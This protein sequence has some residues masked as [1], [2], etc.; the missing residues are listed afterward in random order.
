MATRSGFVVFMR[1]ARLQLNN[2]SFAFLTISDIPDNA[3]EI[4][5]AYAYSLSVVAELIN[6]IN[7][8]DYDRAVYNLGLH[9]M[10]VNSGLPVFESTA[11]AANKKSGRG[12]VNSTSDEGTSTSI[13]LPDYL[14]KQSPY[15]ME[16]DKTQFGRAYLAILSRYNLLATFYVG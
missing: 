12:F 14:I 5:E 11:T 1:K 3:A 6:S 16:L 13:T 15:M 2:G 7:P 8:L 10:A 4:D 9:D